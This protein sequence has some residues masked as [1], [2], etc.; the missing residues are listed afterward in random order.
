M[1]LELIPEISDTGGSPVPILLPLSLVLGVSMI[2]DMYE[3][4]KRHKSD[5]KENKKEVLI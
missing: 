3:D 5:A 4:Y 1:F 2:K